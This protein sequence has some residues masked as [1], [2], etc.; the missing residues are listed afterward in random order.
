[1]D[2]L[3][4]ETTEVSTWLTADLAVMGVSIASFIVVGLW[5]MARHAAVDRFAADDDSH[6]DW[7]GPVGQRRRQSGH[8]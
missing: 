7:V 6:G 8:Q 2:Q 3:L 5:W 4:A 1:M